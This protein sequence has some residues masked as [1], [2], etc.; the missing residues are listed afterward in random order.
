MRPGPRGVHTSHVL[1]RHTFRLHN[2]AKLP[3]S[4]HRTA[5]GK[6]PTPHTAKNCETMKGP[7]VLP[8]E[9]PSCRR[10]I[11]VPVTWTSYCAGSELQAPNIGPHPKPYNAVA[12]HSAAN[13]GAAGPIAAGSSRKPPPM[14]EAATQM[15]TR[16]RVCPL[17]RPA[18]HIAQKRE[19]TRPPQK[20]DTK[21]AAVG[22]EPRP[23]RKMKVASQVP[24]RPGPG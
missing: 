7:K 23:W 3:P 20:A 11:C 21:R 15:Q 2:A 10:V 18:T 16:M 1:R 13:G 14:A 8:A 19:V 12:T 24:A 17:T 9:T 4:E 22:S 6:T 5:H